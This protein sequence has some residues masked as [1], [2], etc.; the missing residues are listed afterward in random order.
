MIVVLGCSAVTRL[1]LL[2]SSIRVKLTN[3]LTGLNTV[4]DLNKFESRL[5]QMRELMQVST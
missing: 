3:S 5:V 1:C 4:W 2:Q